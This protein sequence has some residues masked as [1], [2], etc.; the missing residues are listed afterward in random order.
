MTHKKAALIMILFALILSGCSAIP[1]M[2]PPWLDWPPADVTEP[3]TPTP[4]HAVATAVPT[5]TLPDGTPNAEPTPTDAVSIPG[6]SFT[7][8]QQAGNPFYLPNFNHPDADCNWMGV[9]GQVFGPEGE[10]LL[11]VFIEVGDLGAGDSAV[12]TGVTGDAQAYGLGGYEIKLADTVVATSGVY[13]VQAFN[14]EG[15]PLSERI[16]FDT[17]IDCERNLILLNL[18]YTPLENLSEEEPTPVPTLDPYP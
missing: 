7:Y 8:T 9:A 11:G 3:P 4:T 6:G 18:V 5:Q 13:W 12:F 10:P 17:F 1:E 14:A 15:T 16:F 2:L